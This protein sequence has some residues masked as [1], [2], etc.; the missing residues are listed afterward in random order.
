[1]HG[2]GCILLPPLLALMAPPIKKEDGQYG[3]GYVH[4][5]SGVLLEKRGIW[6][7]VLG[8]DWNVGERAMTCKQFY[9]QMSF[10]GNVLTFFAPKPEESFPFL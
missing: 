10:R 9:P 1:M 7:L 6:R 2:G 5:A 3:G 4:C 8:G